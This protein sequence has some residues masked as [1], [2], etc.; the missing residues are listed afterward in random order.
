MLWLLLLPLLQSAAAETGIDAWLRYARVPNY[1]SLQ[2]AVP[3]RIVALNSSSASPVYTASQELV[4]GFAGILGKEVEVIDSASNMRPYGSDI[5][6]GLLVVG[7]VA[8]FAEASVDVGL[9]DELVNDGYHIRI[10]GSDAHIIGANAR[11]ALH[12]AF[13]YLNA[14]AQ[15][16]VPSESY[17]SNPDAPIRWVNHWDNLQDG[18]THGSVERGYGGESI[19]YW[20]GSVREDLSRVPQYARLLASV[21]INAAIVNNV[22]ANESMVEPRIVKGLQRIADLMRPYGVQIGMAL[23]FAT[24]EL[25][26]VLDTFD[27][28]NRSVIDF[29]QERT[30]MIYQHVPDLAG[31]LIKASSEGQPGPLTYNRTLADGANLFAKAVRPYGGITMFRAFV[32]D[33]T[34][35]NQTGNWKDDRANAA[36]E[37][38]DGLDGSFDDNVV[39]QTQDYLNSDSVLVQPIDFQV[40]EPVSPLFARLQ[41]TASAV[42]LQI[43][44]EY[45]GQQDHVFYFAD[46]WKS[47]LDFDLRVDGE[48]SLV[49]DIVAGRRFNQPL[50]GYAAVS[51]IGLNQTWLGSHLAMSNLYLYGQ[52]AW[53]P[54]V[55]SAGV[56]EDWTRLTFGF[57]QDV[58]DTV[59]EISLESWPTYE[60]YTGNLGI[61]TLTD[62]LN[63]HYGPNPASQDGNPWG[64]WTRADADSIGMD[65][66]IDNGTGFAGQYP[67]EV[68]QIY[69][70]IETTPDDL[71]LWFHHVPYTYELNSGETVIQHFYN[72]HYAGSTNAQTFPTRWQALQGKMD[73]QQWSETLHKFVYQAGHSIVWRDAINDFYYNL[74]GIPDKLGRVGHHPYRVEAESMELDGYELYPVTPWNT[75]SNKTCIVTSSNSTSGTASTNLDVESGT[76]DVAVNYFDQA[77]GRAQWTLYIDGTAIGEWSGDSDIT[78]SH[79]PVLYIDG[80]TAIRITFKDVDIPSRATLK[81]VG[82]PDGQEPAPVDYVSIFP[83]GV[84]D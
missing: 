4:M 41:N 21:G 82:V 67:P 54:S 22:N 75:A 15:G 13:N 17:T 51:G 44:Q 35:L 83:P 37:F 6:S 62:I 27:P 46:L 18:G 64:Q 3:G 78:L 58:I 5:D 53:N 38:F 19:F 32:Y 49:K 79:A 84:V 24:P 81:I 45:L 2:D 68:A 72:A 61:Q 71:L 10:S 23:N 40:R 77:I 42:E 14:L 59:R 55:S 50:G 16:N 1:E 26:G 31:F 9:E 66:T 74:S 25:L 65:R 7:T 43:T 80:Q 60:N 52:M 28:L 63:A 8:Q 56:I 34:T 11:G 73:E 76:Y 39:I 69:D 57:N 48:E 30:D 12:G 47:I 70:N 20:N 29:W 36:V 33:Y